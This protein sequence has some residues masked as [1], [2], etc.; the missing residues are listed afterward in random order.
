MIGTPPTDESNY[1]D[2]IEHI[3][4]NIAASTGVPTSQMGLTPPRFPSVTR[5]GQGQYHINLKKID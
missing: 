2:H 4:A 1:Q 3:K 5:V